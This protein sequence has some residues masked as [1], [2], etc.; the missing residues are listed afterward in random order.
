MRLAL[1]GP[2]A[3]PRLNEACDLCTRV[4]RTKEL[5]IMGGKLGSDQQ[6]M[7]FYP[8]SHQKMSSTGT[9]SNGSEASMHLHRLMLSTMEKSLHMVRRKIVFHTFRSDARTDLGTI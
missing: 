2:W 5:T 3:N 7:K 4:S 9:T 6:A 8:S 1:E